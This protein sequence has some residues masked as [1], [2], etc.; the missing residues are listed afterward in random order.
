MM[1]QSVPEGLYL[2][3]EIHTAAICKEL[4]S[5]TLYHVDPGWMPG[6]H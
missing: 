1:E 4:Q 2:L 6:I 5:N 3:E